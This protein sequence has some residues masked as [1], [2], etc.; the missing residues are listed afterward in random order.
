MPSATT[1]AAATVSA[2]IA[3]ELEL[4]ASHVFALMG[5]GNA[6]FLDAVVR[7]GA[8]QV[9]TVRH[10]AATVAA[11]DAW[12]RASGTLAV[13]TTTYGP[14]YTNALT[15][16]A[17]AAMAHVPLVLVVGDQPASGPRPWDVD[18]AAIAAAVGATTIVASA[19]DATAAARRAVQ[20]ALV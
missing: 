5:N 2:A 15:P 12:F 1:P 10:E 7:R 20:T 9:T 19:A 3:T 6:W 16:L 18:Q 14:G 4:H 8:M 13:A 17:E 11:A